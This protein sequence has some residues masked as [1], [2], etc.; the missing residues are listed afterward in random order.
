MGS[1]LIA[2]LVGTKNSTKTMNMPT[3]ES[4]MAFEPPSNRFA[5]PT[6]DASCQKYPGF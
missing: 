5:Q 3:V 4:E 2:F 6:L 1:P